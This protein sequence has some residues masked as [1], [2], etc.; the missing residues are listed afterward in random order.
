MKG[1]ERGFIRLGHNFDLVGTKCRVFDQPEDRH[2]AAPRANPDR[3]AD[4]LQ[5]SARFSTLHQLR[6][7]RSDRLQYKYHDFARRALAGIGQRIP[8]RLKD[9]QRNLPVIR[10]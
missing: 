6:V 1:F 2:S 3:Y 8:H 10:L 5:A 4:S 9:R 7:M